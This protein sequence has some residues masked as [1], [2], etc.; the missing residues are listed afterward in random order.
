MFPQSYLKAYPYL[1]QRFK[2]W[3]KDRKL[4]RS[5]QSNVERIS[6]KLPVLWEESNVQYRKK[7]FRQIYEESKGKSRLNLVAC[8]QQLLKNEDCE[9]ES[10]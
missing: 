3:F 5:I 9:T 6:Q 2:E 7:R 1:Q 8:L 4:W 10:N